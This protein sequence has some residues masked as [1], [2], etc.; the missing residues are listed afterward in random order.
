MATAAAQS[1]KSVDAGVT[2][3]GRNEDY[4]GQRRTALYRVQGPAVA[5]SSGI[6]FDPRTVGFD[7]PV[8]A[9]FLTTRKPQ[10][11][12]DYRAASYDATAKAIIVWDFTDGDVGTGDDMS[13]LFIDVLVIS[14]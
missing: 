12:N 4:W 13:A 5:G 14:E 9:V 10:S 11:G 8:A 6:A 2:T 3:S 1:V 7:R